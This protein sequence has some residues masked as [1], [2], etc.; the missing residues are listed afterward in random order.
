MRSIHSWFDAYGESHRNP[1]NELIHWVCVPVIFFCVVGFLRSI[2][3]VFMEVPFRLDLAGVGVAALL[4]FYLGLSPRIFL[5][6]LLW[7]LC[8]LFGTAWLQN[9]AGWPLW[10]ICAVLFVAAWIGQFIGHHIEGAKPS[11]LQDLVFLLVGPAWLL[12]KLYKRFGIAY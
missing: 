3:V 6:M 2:P 7:C 12:G 10:A 4:I 8:C 1:K 9:N 11:F 5:G